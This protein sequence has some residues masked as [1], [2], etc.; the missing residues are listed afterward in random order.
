VLCTYHDKSPAATIELSL[1]SPMF[2]E[3]GPDAREF[4]GVVAFFPQG[5]DENNLEWLFPTISYVTNVFNRFCVLSLTYRSNW[6]VTMLAPLRDHLC[7]RDPKSSP[8]LCTSKECYFGRLLVDIYPGKP[9]YEEAGWIKSEDVN[10]ERLLDVFT[11]IDT[12]SESA[13]DVC[14]HFMG[15]LYRHKPRLVLLT[16]VAPSHDACMGLH[17]WFPQS[18]ITWSASDFSYSHLNALQ[19]VGG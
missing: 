4:L 14:C 10:A 19:N 18:E 6:F 9:G 17:G 16:T 2:Q 15:H 7:P 3:L 1:A 13:W 8:L 5:V 11:T 12:D